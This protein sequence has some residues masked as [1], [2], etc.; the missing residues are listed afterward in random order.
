MSPFLAAI[1]F[2]HG[3]TIK[4]IL[5]DILQEQSSNFCKDNAVSSI[6]D[7]V[8]YETLTLALRLANFD[9]FEFLYNAAPNE[10]IKMNG[11]WLLLSALEQ[12]QKDVFKT[13]VNDPRVEL[14]H[15]RSDSQYEPRG[16]TILTEIARRGDVESLRS[17]LG[18]L[19]T[20]R[21]KE[22]M[23]LLHDKGDEEQCSPLWYAA[24]WGH[25]EVVE[26]LCSLDP[27]MI[28]PQLLCLGKF[29]IHIV[30]TA[31][32]GGDRRIMLA[33][34]KVCVGCAMGTHS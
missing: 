31:A 26:A 30:A 22:I 34:L 23:T 7:F 33:L 14:T 24:D 5:Q 18:L 21:R 9:T 10:E 32:R 17:L 12:R 13:L 20:N 15:R 2:K 19:E 3:P 1:Y 25:T 27:D 16:R 8:T 28:R 6:Q 29:G 4:A 11:N